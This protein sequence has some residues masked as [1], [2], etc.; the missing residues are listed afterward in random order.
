MSFD[1]ARART[2]AIA[3]A[4]AAAE[5]KHVASVR[6]AYATI[7]QKDVARVSALPFSASLKKAD[8]A[9]QL[10]QS[11]KSAMSDILMR[12]DD[13]CTEGLRSST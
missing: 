13:L 12:S 10:T 11:V 8:G 7:G 2:S 9:Q 6:R 1:L 5:A 3:T 4:D